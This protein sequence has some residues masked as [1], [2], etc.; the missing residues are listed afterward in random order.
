[1]K[2]KKLQLVGILALIAAIVAVA[3]KFILL[4]EDKTIWTPQ[5]GHADI[6]NT[7][8][9]GPDSRT[10]P[11]CMNV[12]ITPGSVYYSQIVIT[13]GGTLNIDTQQG[14]LD[15]VIELYEGQNR[16]DCND[17]SGPGTNGQSAMHTPVQGTLKAPHRYV[18]RVGVKAGTTPQ[19][20]ASHPIIVNVLLN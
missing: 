14:T 2:I 17:D 16:L 12:T 3:I 20:D 7:S 10:R 4:I 5:F 6:H 13:N 19:H 1:M 8:T 18:F 11:M 15:T 9:M